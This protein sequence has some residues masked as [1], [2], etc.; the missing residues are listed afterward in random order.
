MS[1]DPFRTPPVMFLLLAD[2]RY[3]YLSGE[4]V[5]EVGHFAL[6]ARGDSDFDDRLI[7][8]HGGDDRQV[9][10]GFEDEFDEANLTAVHPVST[11]R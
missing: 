5:H 1:R 8:I 9:V 3:L 11:N 2:G 7:G 6:A 10:I 4:T